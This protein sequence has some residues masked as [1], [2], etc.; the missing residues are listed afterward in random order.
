MRKSYSIFALFMALTM[1]FV[2]LSSTAP[3]KTVEAKSTDSPIPLSA[4]RYRYPI[5]RY[6]NAKFLSGVPIDD[7]MTTLP[8][9]NT[10]T[11]GVNGKTE[12]HLVYA[13]VD[14]YDMFNMK[15][16]KNKALYIQN[17]ENCSPIVAENY[18][19]YCH[20]FGEAVDTREN[21]LPP[22]VQ[23]IPI[24]AADH[25]VM[26][27]IEIKGNPER[28]DDGF[29]YAKRDEKGNPTGEYT[30]HV[31]KT[32]GIVFQEWDYKPDGTP[33]KKKGKVVCT[34]MNIKPGAKITLIWTKKVDWVN[35]DPTIWDNM[36][37]LRQEN[38]KGISDGKNED[39]TIQYK[40]APLP[41][42]HKKPGDTEIITTHSYTLDGKKL[43]GGDIEFPADFCGYVIIP[44]S[45]F[46]M[47]W[48]GD[49]YDGMLNFKKMEL[50]DLISGSYWYH[51]GTVIFDEYCFWG[52]T[53][54]KADGA[55]DYG[56][57]SFANH[58]DSLINRKRIKIKEE[59]PI[60]KPSEKAPEKIQK[61]V[62]LTDK[63]TNVSIEAPKNSGLTS[64]TVFHAEIVDPLAT[65]YS[66]QL[67]ERLFGNDVK[68]YQ[69]YN[70]FLGEDGDQEPNDFVQINFPI[71]DGM[72]PEACQ[73]YTL[74]TDTIVDKVQVPFTLSKDKMTISIKINKL[75]TYIIASEGKDGPVPEEVS[76]T[77]SSKGELSGSE[78]SEVEHVK[79]KS[80]LTWLWITIAAVAIV[81]IC[82]VVFLLLKNKKRK[83]GQAEENI[84]ENEEL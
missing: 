35:P 66:K 68:Q 9:L 50:C 82:I 83:D 4:T 65:D 24:H 54:A 3:Q 57:I 8:Y 53:F 76:E 72:E 61:D 39:G 55:Y 19:S 41:D 28:P 77:E 43:S 81:I 11:K 84:E 7:N 29:S 46:Q 60:E 48:D 2:M 69:I 45:E 49:D 33:K 52:P 17:Q 21:I 71:P 6:E 12:N 80:N 44:F 18:M 31:T 15:V 26:F 14:D 13:R 79:Q 20:R 22:S 32:A 51:R 1:T 70:L 64:K 74:S 37:Y 27:H 59:K 36:D 5:M 30:K 10:D 56:N 34:A 38:G 58:R 23:G 42:R 78:I 40:T 62:V 73:V 63:K 16:G 47:C 67:Y 75:G 25:G